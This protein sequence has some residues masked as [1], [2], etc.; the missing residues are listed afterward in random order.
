[1]YSFR[2]GFVVAALVA[3][4][5]LAIDDP[6]RIEQGQISG[7]PGNDPAVRVYKGIPYATP[8][9]GELR[10]KA[11]KSAASWQGVRKAN[12]F[13]AVCYQNPY[14]ANSVYYNPPEPRSE[15][16]L[17]LNV[18]TG[19]KSANE[20][21]PV[22]VW[23]YGGALTRGSGSLPLYDGEALARKGVVLVTFNYRLGIFG[24]YAHP[25]LTKESDRGSSGNY[26][27]LDQIAALEWVQKNIAA[28]GGDPKRVTIF[29]ES[30]GS[31]SVNYLV[32]TPLAKGL[33]QRAIGESG[34]D[35]AA[36]R[37]LSDAEAAGAKVA[38]ALHAN[39]I[40]ELRAKSA[41]ELVKVPGGAG[42]NVDGWMLPQDVY[43]IFASGKQNDVPVLIGSNAD[44]AR[45]L[46][47]W[48][49]NGTAAVFR[50]QS[51]KRFG[52]LAEEFFKVYPASTDQ[53]AETSHYASFRDI[54]FGWEMRTW[55]RMQEKTGKSKAYLYYFTRIPPGPDSARYRAYHASEIAYVFG[56]LTPPSPWED[57]DRKLSAAISSYWVN[58]ATSGDPNGKKLVKWPAYQAKTDSA[59]ELG[60]Q[61]QVR[62]AINKPALDFLDKYFER[63]RGGGQTGASNTR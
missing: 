45:S 52:D 3:L 5:L 11:P 27:I 50:D 21:R 24:F 1:M 53:E 29:G 59:L 7:I 43:T 13:S 54:T 58:F 20:K 15:D 25:E 44:E 18:W 62:T 39:S 33:F 31:W 23:I 10:W 28:F 36:V 2:F 12:Q 14:P 19:A 48:P 17:Y 46:A 37:K 42:P 32:A 26:G 63:Q 41:D 60:D 49:A 16:C 8:P 22:M 38:A 34:G 9:V 55:A 56:N 30:A 40:Q 61:I 47:P 35:F 51:R 6:V 4:P 57:T